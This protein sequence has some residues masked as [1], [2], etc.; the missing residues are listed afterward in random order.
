MTSRT[1]LWYS[2]SNIML[3]ITY[4]DF[5]SN[6]LFYIQFLPN[7]TKFISPMSSHLFLWSLCFMLNKSSSR[8][9]LLQRPIGAWRNRNLSSVIGPIFLS[10]P[11]LIL[12]LP[13]LLP[14]SPSEITLWCKIDLL[15]A[16][17]FCCA[18]RYEITFWATEGRVARDLVWHGGQEYLLWFSGSN[19]K[20]VF[21]FSVSLSMVVSR[22]G[23]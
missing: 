6:V 7:L 2:S 11:S 4:V 8:S 15:C 23:M 18:Y 1:F 9:G 3:S 10:P 5:I 13:H 17:K 14:P 21:V 12:L 19:V 22:S 16:R 20:Y